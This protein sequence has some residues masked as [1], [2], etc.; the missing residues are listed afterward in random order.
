MFGSGFGNMGYINPNYAIP[1]MQTRLN[2]AMQQPMQPTFQQAPAPAMMTQQQ[3]LKGRIVSSADE[4]KA[5]IVDLDGSPTFFPCPAETCIYV[6]SIDLNGSPVIQKFVPEQP[7][8]QPQYAEMNIVEQL[9]QR[10]TRLEQN[11][12]L[13]MEGGINNVQSNANDANDGAAE[14]QRQSNA[15]NAGNVGKQPGFY[16]RRANNPK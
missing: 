1:G 11:L 4:V 12:P 16:P 3:S 7:Q 10:V 6:K 9:I 14:Q 5:A 13:N 8:Q 15:G 2:A